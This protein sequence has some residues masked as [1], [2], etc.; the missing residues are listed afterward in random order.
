M[1]QGRR[2]GWYAWVPVASAISFDVGTAVRGET[3]AELMRQT[4]VHKRRGTMSRVTG[5][6]IYQTLGERPDAED[7]VA[8]AHDHGFQW[9]TAQAIEGHGL[10]DR[11]WVRGMRKAT[12]KRHM[13]LGV[14]GFV[15][16]PSPQPIAEARAMVKAIE[17][18]DA[19]FAIVNAEIQY[20]HSPDPDSKRFVNEYRRLKPDFPSYFSSFGRPKFHSSLDYGA[21]ASADFQGMPQAYESLNPTL[22]KPTQCVEDWARFFPKHGLRP[23][24]SCFAEAGKPRLPVSRLVK[25]VREVPGLRFNVYRHGTVSNAELK[26]LSAVE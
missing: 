23:T 13:R 14:H 24:L 1:R 17:I 6:W 18:A 8:R 5:L 12:K 15:G 26:A 25:S 7:A 3:D 11:D 21:W 20:E 9:I 16:R 4:E 2:T 10:L 22:L 19:D